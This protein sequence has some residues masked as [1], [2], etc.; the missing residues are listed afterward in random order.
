MRPKNNY[1]VI[2]INCCVVVSWSRYLGK[3]MSKYRSICSVGS[4]IV[5]LDEH[6]AGNWHAAAS[7]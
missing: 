1:T 5:Q 7:D 3:Q 2:K 4:S 6:Q